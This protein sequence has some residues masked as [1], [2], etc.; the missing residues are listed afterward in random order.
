MRCVRAV[1]DSDARCEGL[2]V[3]LGQTI[4]NARVPGKHQARRLD[5][6]VGASAY[7]KVRLLVRGKGAWIDSGILPGAI[8]LNVME[9]IGKGRVELPAEAVVESNI[10][11]DLPAILR[12]KIDASRSNVLALRCAL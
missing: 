1:G 5:A 2:V 4:L 8:S 11:L 3:S 9:D 10:R 12:E 6:R 7:S